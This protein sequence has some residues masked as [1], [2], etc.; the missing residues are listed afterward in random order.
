MVK[1]SVSLTASSFRER[2]A[3]NAD[4][5][6]PRPIAV[7]IDRICVIDPVWIVRDQELVSLCE[8]TV[9]MRIVND[10]CGFQRYRAASS[11]N[12]L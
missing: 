4:T 6:E 5:D 12:C 8:L 10:E 9:N 3:R 2:K 11:P 7:N 1:T